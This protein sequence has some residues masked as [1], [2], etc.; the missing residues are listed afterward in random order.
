M[1]GLGVKGRMSNIC[2]A[3]GCVEVCEFCYFFDGH[4]VEVEQRDD[5]KDIRSPAI[6]TNDHATGHMQLRLRFR[7]CTVTPRP[8][9]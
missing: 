7:K 5:W 9:A 6:D 2:G 3:Y 4:G 1:R 8:P